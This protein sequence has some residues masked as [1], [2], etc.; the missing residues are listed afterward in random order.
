[1]LIPMGILASSGGVAGAYELITSA[2]VSGSSTYEVIFNSVPQNYKHLQL[3]A[4]VS[5]SAGSG[6]SNLAL[7]F[8]STGGTSYN[9]HMLTADGS[10]VTSAYTGGVQESVVGLNV[11]NN[12]SIFGAYV[13]DI[14]DYTSTIKNTTVKS[15]FGTYNAS[16]N[17]SIGL[18]SSLF[19]N[20]SAITRI[21][22]H[23]QD[24]APYQAN[25]RFSLYG[26]K[27]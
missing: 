5:A 18:W 27:G 3:R 14:L 22:C 19:T 23:Q 7:E 8:N 13:V 20:T 16:G 25:T 9:R 1:M 11:G 26:I 6:F 2:T 10:A 24:G 17:K 15:Q 21:L 12:S 4:I